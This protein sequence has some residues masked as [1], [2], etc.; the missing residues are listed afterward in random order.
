MIKSA[1]K[2]AALLV[3]PIRRL[4]EQRDSMLRDVDALSHRLSNLETAFTKAQSDNHAELEKSMS[5]IRTELTPF[6]RFGYHLPLDHDY[7]S[8]PPKFDPPIWADG[9][10]LP[11]PPSLERHGHDDSKYLDWGKYDHDVLVG[12]IRRLKPQ[13][14]I[15]PSWI[16]DVPPVGCCVI[17]YLK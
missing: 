17:L 9:E 8:T 2:R 5:T 3:P 16:S 12:H 13:S 6:P 10:V 4:K 11:L 7:V 15:W 14:R 1:L